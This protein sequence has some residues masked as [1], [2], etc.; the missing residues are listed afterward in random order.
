MNICVE[1]FLGR[2]VDHTKELLAAEGHLDKVLARKGGRADREQV[3]LGQNLVCVVYVNPVLLEHRLGQAR[4][5][6]ELAERRGLRPRHDVPALGL[7]GG[8]VGRRGG[9]AVGRWSGGAVGR[10]GGVGANN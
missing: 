1:L 3:L 6:E 8:V 5:V 4:L 9:G 10:W 7:G 2:G